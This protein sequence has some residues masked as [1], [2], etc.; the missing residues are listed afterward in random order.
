L[1]IRLDV[2]ESSMQMILEAPPLAA[3]MPVTATMN[4]MRRMLS[5]VRPAT[6][7][8]ALRMLRSAF[9]Q[10]TLAE[11]IAAIASDTK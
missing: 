8:E 4:R 9:P 6:D 11:R 10:T 7:A 5:T 2:Q 3:E 1:N